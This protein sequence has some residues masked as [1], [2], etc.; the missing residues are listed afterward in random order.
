MPVLF[1]SVCETSSQ[2]L[3]CFLTWDKR[4]GQ[5]MR[6]TDTQ[7]LHQVTE[8]FFGFSKD[9]SM[10]IIVHCPDASTHSLPSEVPEA[11]YNQAVYRLARC[12]IKGV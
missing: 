8:Q 3:L 12:V 1:Y 7:P 2:T 10:P 5:K 11:L 9:L 4:K 6:R